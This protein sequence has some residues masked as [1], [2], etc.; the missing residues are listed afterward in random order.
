M[1]VSYFNTV[2]V[3]N[4]ARGF[5]SLIQ[6]RRYPSKPDSPP[7][8]KLI[9]PADSVRVK[10]IAVLLPF[11]HQTACYARFASKRKIQ[12]GQRGEI[13][14]RRFRAADQLRRA[15]GFQQHF[16][17]AELAVVIVAHGEPVRARIVDD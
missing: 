12:H 5:G 16:R 11:V 13:I 17:A 7:Y 8:R 4:E 3:F 1:V 9:V 2:P 14:A 15:V 6:H 10:R